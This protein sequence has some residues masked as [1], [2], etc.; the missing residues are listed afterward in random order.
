MPWRGAAPRLREGLQ[1]LSGLV[2]Y[3]RT[4]SGFP[5]LLPL[6]FVFPSFLSFYRLPFAWFVACVSLGPATGNLHTWNVHEYFLSFVLQL[7]SGMSLG[8][9]RYPCKSSRLWQIFNGKLLSTRSMIHEYRSRSL[10]KKIHCTVSHLRDSKKHRQSLNAGALHMQRR[11][12]TDKKSIA[13]LL[14]FA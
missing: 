1:L 8:N 5:L 10:L 14:T 2:H 4:P 12:C 7:L 13:Q 11:V 9:R 3:V 6:L